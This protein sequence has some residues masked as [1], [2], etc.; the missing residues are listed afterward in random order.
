[1]YVIESR[2]Y[3]FSLGQYFDKLPGKPK[4]AVPQKKERYSTGVVY[5][6]QQ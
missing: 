4:M 1:M 6:E 3:A 2:K 5:M